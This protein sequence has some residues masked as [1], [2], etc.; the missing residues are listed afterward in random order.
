MAKGISLQDMSSYALAFIV[1]AVIL[2]ITATILTGVQK[3]QCAGGT[4]WNETLGNCNPL[5]T[6]IA[7][8]ATGFGI[9][10]T[11]TMSQWL[12][13]IAVII[14]AAIVIG[15]IVTSFRG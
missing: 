14:A 12:P 3:T 13:I 2:G 7:S 15:L 8:N 4:V 1:I 6:T 9:S 5:N 10:G 11:G